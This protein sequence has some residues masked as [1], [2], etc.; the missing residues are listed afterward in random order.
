MVPL[1]PRH[2]SLYNGGAGSSAR[3]ETIMFRRLLALSLTLVT[4][5]FATAQN[6]I[7]YQPTVTAKYQDAVKQKGGPLEGKLLKESP[8]GVTIQT[9]IGKETREILVPPD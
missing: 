3:R 7:Y 9:V 8:A 2:R 1:P 6:R 5:A 4:A